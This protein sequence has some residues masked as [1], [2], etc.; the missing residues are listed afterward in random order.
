MKPSNWKKEYLDDPMKPPKIE[1]V[2][3]KDTGKFFRGVSTGINEFFLLDKQKIK[4][5][6]I[7]EKYFRYVIGD[8]NPEGRLDDGDAKEFLLNVNDTN[9]IIQNMQKSL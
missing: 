2:E 7:D 6:K 8:N 9:E 3:L 4:Q 5:H 1:M